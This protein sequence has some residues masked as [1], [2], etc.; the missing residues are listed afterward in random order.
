MLG[1]GEL[2]GLNIPGEKPGT[3]PAEPPKWGGVGMMMAFGEGFLQTPL[4]L[5][6]L[7]SAIANGGTMYY[8]Q[9]PR[10][11]EEVENFQPKV[12]RTLELAPNGIAD[13]K[14][15]NVSDPS[16]IAGALA[17]LRERAGLTAAH[18]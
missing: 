6:G 3:V 9:Y 8:L 4:E 2:A 12:K 18:P 10:T 7:L 15:V 14:L 5:A 13:V 17:S 1:L 16:S 11:P